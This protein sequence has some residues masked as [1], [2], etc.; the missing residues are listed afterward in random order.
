MDNNIN[1]NFQSNT[2]DNQENTIN[3]DNSVNTNYIN[4]NN[5][6]YNMDNQ[7]HVQNNVGQNKKKFNPILIVI[8]LLLVLIISGVFV[9]FKVVGSEKSVKNLNSVF[10]PNK[11]IVI[12]NN[13]KYGYITTSGE[14]MIEPQYN[15][16]SDFYGDYAIVSVDNPKANEYDL[17]EI[18]D[19]KGNVKLVT[20]SYNPPINY[21][22]NGLW[23]VNNVLY[24]SNLN[25]VF[26]EEISVEYVANGYFK[27]SD[28]SKKELGII[29]YK[30][31]KIFTVPE[32]YFHVVA[33]ENKYTD[34]DLYAVIETTSPAQDMIISLKSG[35]IL[36]T[37]ENP[38]KYYIGK[39]ENGVFYYYDES[40][41]Q[42]G[43][44]NRRYLFFINNKLA[45]Q[46]T[47]NV[48]DFKVYDY[49]NQ[50]LEID[51]GYDYYKLGKSKRRY[52][53]DV[54]N[55]K[56]LDDK[57]SSS[58]SSDGLTNLSFEGYTKFSVSGKYGLMFEEKVIIPCEYDDINFFDKD[59]FNYM[60]TKGKE[61][62]MLE[63]DKK[64]VLYN[65]K[66]NE[67]ITVFDSKYVY[68]YENST[69]IKIKLYDQNNY[70]IKGYVIYNLLSG[71]S[72]EFDNDDNIS[73]G[74][75]YIIVKEKNKKTYYNT[76]FEQIYVS[77][78][79]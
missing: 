43:Y 79:D 20:D 40:D 37:S 17:T 16:A 21:P 11:P 33:S 54:K 76:N 73:I 9:V 26:G 75:N 78:E 61:L 24:D 67:A 13:G 5:L 19:K 68:S 51:Y 63:K 53:Y 23:L 42:N 7:N 69:F 52:Y 50:I 10:D 30:G 27:Y 62:I 6:N 77:N 12:K 15:S 25:K 2:L 34:D 38:E 72:L 18:I 36:F 58:E 49:E 55:K 57:P 46:T 41:S 39:Q 59:L 28:M 35:D 4:N 32:T 66:E 60:K 8:I 1:N 65:K 3:H 47:E 74:S 45:Y 44:K 48:Y 70:G 14:V 22:N 56:M 71:K 31:K 29:T 64:T